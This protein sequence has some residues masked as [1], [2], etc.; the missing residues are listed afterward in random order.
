[1]PASV[2]HN[3]WKSEASTLGAVWLPRL[4][5]ERLARLAAR[6]STRAFAAVYERY[7]QPLYRYCRSIL[8]DDTD[9]QD[10]LQ[11]TFTRALSALKRG[12]RSAP[13][14]PW[15][16]RIAH[17]ESISVLRRRRGG[18]G[19][20]PL[21]EGSIPL[22][23]SA[24]DEAA[25]RARLGVMLGDLAALPDRARNALVM[26]ELSGLSHEDIAIALGISQGAAKQAIFEA[27]RGLQECAEGR[28]M[29]CAEVCRAIS[30]GDRRVLRGRRVRAHVR[31]C[32]SCAA[33]ASAID[34]RRAE[35]RALVPVLPAAASAAVLSRVI[36]GGAGHGAVA[37]GGAAVAGTAGKTLGVALGS[38]GFAAASLFATAAVSVGGVA[39]VVRL[40][41]DGRPP[42][43]AGGR[44][45]GVA[46]PAVARVSA[47]GGS[48]ATASVRAGLGTAPARRSTAVAT[49]PAR[50]TSTRGHRRPAPP[51][52]RSSAS[53]G[54]SGSP[55]LGESASSSHGHSGSS[56]HG[57]SGS[58][59]GKSGSSHGKSA[60][61]PGHSESSSHG[62]SAASNGNSATSNGQGHAKSSSSAHGVGKQ[63]APGQL[64]KTVAASEQYA[65][66]QTNLNQGLGAAKKVGT[67]VPGSPA[68][69]SGKT[70]K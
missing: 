38:K 67:D 49:L 3:E 15:L 47:A 12:Q 52:G 34:T 10:A 54:Q 20:D 5:D 61:S 4:G 60:S 64:K 65:T 40:S 16:F 27:R 32:A 39:A 69:T 36:H 35:L 18:S 37:G 28:A 30:D 25:E 51:H 22:A 13:L 19:P 17:N 68:L 45:A 56:S 8:R 29:R 33:F 2:A 14:R 50:T 11:S 46:H 48:P 1:V 59:H 26:R 70:H 31:D 41:H 62:N 43:A 7:H 24:E 6:G 66:A 63:T 53:H 9:A 23:P 42:V 44:H 21:D 57:N 58:S 55:S